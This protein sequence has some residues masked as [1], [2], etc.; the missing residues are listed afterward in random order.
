[1]TDS[2]KTLTTNESPNIAGGLPLTLDV[3]VGARVMLRRN[4]DTPKGLVNGATGQLSKIE[5]DK[6]NNV[7]ALYIK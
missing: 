3:A 1:M 7:T 4:L 5:T 2:R 6:N